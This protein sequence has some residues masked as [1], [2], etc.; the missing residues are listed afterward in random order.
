MGYNSL[1]IFRVWNPKTVTVYA[2]RDVL[3]N[4]EEVFDG[5]IQYLKDDLKEVDE[6]LFRNFFTTIKVATQ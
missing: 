3:F 4:E 1:N 6:E 5:D 2:V